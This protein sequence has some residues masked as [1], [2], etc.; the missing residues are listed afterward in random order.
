MQQEAQKWLDKRIEQE[1][2]NNNNTIQLTSQ[3]EESMS[4]PGTI[5]NV[6]I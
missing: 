3:I 6:K 2:D 5:I 1:K 4:V